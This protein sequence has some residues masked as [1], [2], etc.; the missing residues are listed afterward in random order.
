[1]RCKVTIIIAAYNAGKYLSESINS[2]LAQTFNNFELIIV[3]DASTDDTLNIASQYAISDSRIKIINNSVNIGQTKSRNMALIQACGD[4]IAILD[5]DDIAVSDRLEKQVNFLESRPD[6]FLVG[7]GVEEFSEKNSI[8]KS[9]YR[10]TNSWLL[11]LRL[12]KKNCIYHPSI[13]FRNEGFLYREKFRYAEDYDF[14]LC[15]LS[16]GKKL[17]N[18]KDII[19]KYRISETQIKST[20]SEIEKYYAETARAMY[21]LRQKKICDGYAN[22]KN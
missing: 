13:M 3:N 11:G 12:G 8:R 17:A 10:I 18:I 2:I 20:K 1:M 7:G 14:Y 6:I 22:M 4:Y 16:A 19:V 21:K 15:L 5:A 9:P